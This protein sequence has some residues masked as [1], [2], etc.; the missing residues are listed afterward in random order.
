MSLVIRQAKVD[1]SSKLAEL[2][3]IAPMPDKSC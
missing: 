1:D 3:N 2:M